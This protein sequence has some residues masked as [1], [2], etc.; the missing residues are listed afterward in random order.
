MAAPG[1]HVTGPERT[2]PS[3]SVHPVH[4][5]CLALALLLALQTPNAAQPDD[6][7]A[8]VRTTILAIADRW[9]EGWMDKEWDEAKGTFKFPQGP[10]SDAFEHHYVAAER[11]PTRGAQVQWAIAA[12]Q[13]GSRESGCEPA[14]KGRRSAGCSYRRD[15]QAGQRGSAAFRGADAGSGRIN[16]LGCATRGKAGAWLQHSKVVRSAQA[17]LTPC[18][19][20]ASAVYA[21]RPKTLF[22]NSEIPPLTGWKACPTVSGGGPAFRRGNVGRN[23]NNE[24]WVRLRWPS[25]SAR[26][27]TTD[28]LFRRSPWI[29][30][31]AKP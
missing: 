3:W 6:G 9:V 16:R 18:R 10:Y 15:P 8:A 17:M 22:P 27:M 26:R 11:Q 31:R 20:R 25:G 28:A 4:R 2:V 21:R 29:W 7:L 1:E 19:P 24:S 23:G 5:L 13:P 12:A 30:L 14:R